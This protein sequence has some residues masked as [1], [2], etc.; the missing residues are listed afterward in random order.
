LR[1][2]TWRGFEATQLSGTH[3]DLHVALWGDLFYKFQNNRAAVVSLK[4]KAEQTRSVTVNLFKRGQ[5][6][7]IP[8]SRGKS[9]APVRLVPEPSPIVFRWKI[10]GMPD[11][12][13]SPTFTENKLVF[14]DVSNER[15]LAAFY[16]S[17]RA[18]PTYETANHF[19]I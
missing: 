14:P 12:T 3:E 15:V 19:L 8:P 2:R 5:L 1:T 6:R 18:A 4:G 9:G 16:T 7:V 17:A 11:L 13:V 10:R